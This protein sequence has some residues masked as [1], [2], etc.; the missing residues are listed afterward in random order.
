MIESYFETDGDE[1]DGIVTEIGDFITLSKDA[2]LTEFE[3]SVAKNT[4]RKAIFRV[5]L[6][7]SIKEH[8]VFTL[9]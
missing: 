9:Y 2:M 7:Q 6:Y 1:S 8:T 4:Y 3:L 5:E